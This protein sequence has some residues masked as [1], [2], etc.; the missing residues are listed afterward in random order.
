MRYEYGSSNEVLLPNKSLHRE[1]RKEQQ[2]QRQQLRSIEFRINI[3]VL[4]VVTWCFVS[5][6]GHFLGSRQPLSS[7]SLAGTYP[8]V[9]SSLPSYYNSNNPETKIPDSDSDSVSVLIV[10][11][12]NDEAQ[13][14]MANEVAKGARS[15]KNVDVV[16]TTVSKAKFDQVLAADGVILGSSVENANTHPDIQKWI[17]DSW[18]VTQDLSN[19]VGAAF[20]TAGGLSAGEEG[21]MTSLIQTMMIFQMII[22]GGNSWLSPFGASAITYESPFGASEID[23]VGDNDGGGVYSN[24]PLYF[25]KECYESKDTIVHP[26]FLNKGELSRVKLSQ[27]M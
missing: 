21:T 5:L 20:V 14:L 2:H 22:V 1:Q 15:I 4:L 8:S 11:I 27:S 9:S 25:S 17:N 7:V 13:L 19:K 16:T 10:F 12:D 26:L 18:D 6:G 24:T 23:D 3:C